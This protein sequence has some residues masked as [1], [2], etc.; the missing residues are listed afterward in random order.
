MYFIGHGIC[1][2]IKE[3]AL[4]NLQWLIKNTMKFTKGDQEKI[5]WRFQGSV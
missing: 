5:I 4:W 2:G 3:K 1:R